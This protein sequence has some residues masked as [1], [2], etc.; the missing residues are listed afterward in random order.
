MPPPL[1]TGELRLWDL[2]DYA[3]L[4]VCRYPKSG[5]VLCLQVVTDDRVISGWQDGAIRCNGARTLDELWCI[6]AAHRGGT[7]TLSVHIDANVHFIASAGGDCTVRVWRLTNRE[8]VTQYIDHTKSI[9]CVAID[10]QTPN[11]VHTVSDDLSVVTFDI[12][13]NKRRM[14]HL[15]GTGGVITSLTQRRDSELEL[16]SVD[17]LGRIL[18]WDIDYREPVQQM[19]DPSR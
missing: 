18:Q 17:T 6:A 11:F 19:Q 12:K 9:S 8:L 3:C 15:M 7:R 16:V 10:L 13:L 5:A 14:C 4:A 2:S 1:N